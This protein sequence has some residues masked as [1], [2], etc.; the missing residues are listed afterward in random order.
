[1]ASRL[2]GQDINADAVIGESLERATNPMLKPAMLGASLIASI[3]AELPDASA[4][5]I[6]NHQGLI[7]ELRA[8]LPTL[9]QARN[10]W[11]N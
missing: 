6:A 9:L 4:T 2:F 5:Y 3:D 10:G 7:A 11:Q 1:V 8:L